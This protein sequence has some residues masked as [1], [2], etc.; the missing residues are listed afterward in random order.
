MAALTITHTR[1][2]GTIIDGTERGDGTADILKAHGWRWGRS[3][4]AWYIPQSRDR[5]LKT[6]VTRPTAAA[7]EAAGHDVA[8]E[9]DDTAR[10]V[11]EVEAD[12][13]ARQ[14]DRADALAA[15]AEHK[16]ARAG[17]AQRAA[18]AAA[19]QLPEGGEPVKIGHHSETRHRNA[20]TR[21]WNAQGR[22]VRAEEDAATARNRSETATRTTARR[23]APATVAGRI[24]RLE[25]AGRA[26]ARAVAT[27]AGDRR[28]ELEADIRE[29][30]DALAYWRGIRAEQIV[31]GEVIEYSRETIRPGDQ[32]KAG[33][34]WWTVVRANAKTC[35]VYIDVQRGA[36]SSYRPPYGKI[37]EHRPAAR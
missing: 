33:G 37:T 4:S 25:T 16:A 1:E 26:L 30:E 7:L 28:D 17:E 35:T 18:R 5:K 8:L 27:A 2:D 22:A 32:I 15:K 19:Q 14:E 29:N 12:R 24:A 21:S 23:Y 9:V 13:V 20:L 6:W 11:A 36:V 3:L 31:S 10:P 34:T